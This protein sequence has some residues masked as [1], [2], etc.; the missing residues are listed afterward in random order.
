MSKSKILKIQNPDG[1]IEKQVPSFIVGRSTKWCCH[2]G[3][4]FSS[5]SNI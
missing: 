4:Q 3:R 1:N 5:F 2:F